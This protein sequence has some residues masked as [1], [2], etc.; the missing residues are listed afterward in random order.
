MESGSVTSSTAGIR[1]PAP[2]MHT[3]LSLCA[4]TQGQRKSEDPGVS[5]A[6][7]PILTQTLP[8]VS[9]VTWDKSTQHSEPRLPC[10]K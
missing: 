9:P 6:W 5:Q 2:L 4:S 3:S 7:A 1:V 10:K 8:R